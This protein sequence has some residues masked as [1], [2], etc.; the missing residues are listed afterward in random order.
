MQLDLL[1]VGE[2]TILL[3]ICLFHDLHAE[4]AGTARRVFSSAGTIE[5]IEMAISAFN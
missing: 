3:L 4:S 1:V 5:I 2:S